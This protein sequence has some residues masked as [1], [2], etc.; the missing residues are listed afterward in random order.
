MV[1]CIKDDN[2]ENA[3]KTISYQELSITIAKPTHVIW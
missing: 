2:L 1:I 3:L